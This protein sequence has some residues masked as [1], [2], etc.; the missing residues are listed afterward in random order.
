MSET[1]EPSMA[2]P[3]QRKNGDGGSGRGRGMTIAVIVLIALSAGGF[4]VWSHLRDYVST[5]DAQVDGHVAAIA[6]R[7]SGNIAAVLVTDNQQVK[8]GTPLVR[9]DARD[10]QAHVAIA[11]AEVARAESQLR[12]ARVVVPWTDATTESGSAG[13]AAGLADAQAELERARLALEQSS[14]SDLAYA[15][16]NVQTRQAAAERARA[17]LARMKP[18]ADKAEIS[19]IQYD[20]YLA[21]SRGADSELEAARQKMVS[22]RQE[23]TIR[24]AA[25]DVAETRVRQAKASV[26]ASLANRKQVDIRAADAAT[27]EAAV[28]TARANLAAAVLQLGYTEIVAPLD[29]V[30]TRKSV[31][32]GQVVSPGQSLMA[33]VP[34]HD[35][36]ITANFKETQLDEVKVGQRAVIHVDMYGKDIEGRVDSIAGTTGSRMSLMPAENATGNYVKVVQRIPVKIVVATP[37]GVVLR[38]GMNVDARIYTN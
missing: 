11:R 20:S 22:A 38:P 28:A 25:L 37:D 3:E 29:G 26:D 23:S 5:D 27:A 14:T 7:I 9:I 32:T 21:T 12:A 19:R 36:W 13:A 1:V 15:D 16:A 30:V 24:K 10:Y 35:T 17:D 18:L 33:V 31:E 34:L 4:A 2:N 6:A 8:A